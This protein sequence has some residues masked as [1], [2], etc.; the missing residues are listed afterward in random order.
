[1]NVHPKETVDNLI[2]YFISNLRTDHPSTVVLTCLSE[3]GELTLYFGTDV[4]VTP[5]L[6]ETMFIYAKTGERDRATA[7]FNL[8]QPANLRLPSSVQV[9]TIFN[10]H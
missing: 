2:K 3:Q 1:M 9:T 8:M 6:N 5:M 7:L 10:P 4:V